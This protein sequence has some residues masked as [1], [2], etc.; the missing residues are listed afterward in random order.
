MLSNSFISY[1]VSRTNPIAW[2]VV[3]WFPI[4]LWTTSISPT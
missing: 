1:E 2:I 4:G 3:A